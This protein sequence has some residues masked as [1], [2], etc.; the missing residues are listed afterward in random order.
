MAFDLG[1]WHTQ[2]LHA[3]DVQ[4][5]ESSRLGKDAMSPM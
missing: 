3:G 5:D 1:L 2:G 4:T